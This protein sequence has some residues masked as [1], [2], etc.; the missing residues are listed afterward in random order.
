MGPGDF[1]LLG[2]SPFSDGGMVSGLEDVGDAGAF[3]LDGAGVEGETEESVVAVAVV[4]VAFGVTEDVGAEAGDGVGHYEGRE[5]ASGE[6]V[7][8]DGEG[9]VAEVGADP[10]VDALV[11][12]ADEDDVF[13]GGETFG[14]GLGEEVTAGVGED[15]SGVFVSREAAEG[16]GNEIHFEDHSGASSV[17]RVVHSAVLIGGEIA[18]VGAA[19]VD[20]TGFRGAAGDAVIESPF[21]HFGKERHDVNAHS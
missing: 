20:V 12:A 8:A 5:F 14:D 6:D 2:S 11:V 1:E 15:D 10:F 3:E 13:F 17:G 9:F 7:I 19:V 18:G 16:G 21:D 4:T